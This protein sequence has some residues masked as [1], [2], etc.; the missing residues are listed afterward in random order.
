MLEIN[1]VIGF[2]KLYTRPV[3]ILMQKALDLPYQTPK[4][5]TYT[6]SCFMLQKLE[7]VL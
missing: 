3:K 1:L 6:P 7:F 2:S 4:G 5:Y